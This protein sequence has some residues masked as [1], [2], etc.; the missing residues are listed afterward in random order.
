MEVDLSIDTGELFNKQFGNLFVVEFLGSKGGSKYRCKCA[1]G[2]TIIV[3]RN[4]LLNGRSTSCGSCFSVLTED[5]KMRYV[6]ANNDSF[7]FDK[8]D[9]PLIMAHRWYIEKNGY[10]ATKIKEKTFRLTR[11]LLS[12]DKNKYI[13]HINGNPRDNRRL[14][15][16]LSTFTENQRNMRIP[17]HNTTGYKGVSFR[18]DR[19]KFRAYISIGNKTKHIGY[20]DSA[21]NAAIAYDN[22]ARRIFGLFACLNFPNSNEQNCKRIVI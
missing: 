10:V 21:E 14:N 22:K 16:R 18:R 20:Y 2:K 12:P 4:Q 17:S 1:C 8:Q 3:S 7:I 9:L 13:D 5:N 6:V 15:L 19:N 11:L